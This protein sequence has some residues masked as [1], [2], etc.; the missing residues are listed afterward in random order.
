MNERNSRRTLLETTLCFIVS[1][2]LP[3]L[4]AGASAGCALTSKAKAVTPRYF[5]PDPTSVAHTPPKTTSLELQLGQVTSASHLDERIAYRLSSAE[6]GFY[7][8][9]RWTELPEAYLRRALERELFEVQ[10]LKRIIAGAAPALDVELTAFEEVRGTPTRARVTLHFSL[11]DDRRALLERGVDIIREVPPKNSARTEDDAVLLARTLSTTLHD[12][13]VAIAE[14]VSAELQTAT[15]RIT[16]GDNGL[17]PNHQVLN[18]VDAEQPA[19]FDPVGKHRGDSYE[20]KTRGAR[21]RPAGALRVSCEELPS[22]PRASPRH[23]W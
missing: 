10:G 11:H 8:D 15:A 19:E 6:L 13:V 22:A 9:R 5:S 7:D 2:A 12:A 18:A 14:Q 3:A 16:V 17:A 23:D 21:D 1:A 4:A 20:P